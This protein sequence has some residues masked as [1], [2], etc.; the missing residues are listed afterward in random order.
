M[1]DAPAKAPFLSRHKF[2]WLAWLLF[3]ISLLIPTPSGPGANMLGGSAVEVY[4]KA[5]DWSKATPG[6]AG[7]LSMTQVTVLA[8]ALFTHVAFLYTFYVRDDLKLSIAWKA[9]LLAS[10]AIDIA[11]GTVVPDLAKLPAYWVWLASI[12]ALAIGYV[13]VGGAGVVP[14]AKQRKSRSVIDSGGVTPF[15][16]A[17]LA[18]T[19]FWVAVSAGNR[20]SS[21]DSATLAARDPLTSYVNDRAHVLSADE[22]SILSLALQN[23]ELT[24]PSQ[25]ALA[26]YPGVPAGASIDDFTI[27]TAERLPLGRAGLDTGAIL[28]VFMKERAARLEVGYGLE[29]ILTDVDSRRILDANLAPAFARGAYFDGLNAT[30]KA[31]VAPV[32]E[33]YDQGRIPGKTTVWKRQLTADRPNTLQ[34]FWRTVSETSLPVRIGATLLCAI[35][36]L[37]LL[38]TLPQWMRLARDL[39]RGVA[40]L[41]AR[42]PFLEGMES[43]Q[44]E[45]LWE[46]VRVFFWTLG[47]LIPAAGVIIIAGGGTF[48]GAGAL[49][50]W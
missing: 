30:L 42:R 24:T 23:F 50:H 21:S 16:W 4:G 48:G 8:L 1:A 33:A 7:A 15:V 6:T 45:A 3:V 40:N 29:G 46:S 35:V 10:L 38:M 13:L 36:G 34:R 11:V 14:D 49:I 25:I 28:F 31:I 39:W 2:F 44:G 22:A 47:I 9:L 12:V 32:K 17:L 20:T 37:F 43:L 19:L 5:L 41:I 26:I 27:R 18:F